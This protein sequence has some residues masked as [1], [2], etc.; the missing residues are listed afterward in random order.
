MT[1]R[2]ADV[3]EDVT[4]HAFKTGYRHASLGLESISIVSPLTS[5]QVDSARAYRNEAPCAEA[6][7]KSG[8]KRS[9]IFFTSKVPPKSLGYE[10]TQKA[11]DA[12]F[13]ETGID[14]V[15][16]YLSLSSWLSQSKCSLSLNLYSAT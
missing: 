13:K 16:L 4:L 5:C 1:F 14:Y 10:E 6:I 9:D 2:P 8:L 3:T 7:R 12:T 11:I 15:D